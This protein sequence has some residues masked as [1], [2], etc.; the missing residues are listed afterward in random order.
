MSEIYRPAILAIFVDSVTD[1]SQGLFPNPG[2][3]Y[4]FVSN[5]FEIFGNKPER[6]DS[7]V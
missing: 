1:A 7:K 4:S 6:E 2:E 5:F 3:R